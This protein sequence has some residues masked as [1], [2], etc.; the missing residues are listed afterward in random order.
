MLYIADQLPGK[1][2]NFQQKFSFRGKIYMPY[3]FVLCLGTNCPI[4]R[5]C[6]RFTVKILGRQDFF[7]TTPYDFTTNSCKHFMSNRPNEN[8]IRMKAYE[9]WQQAGYPDGKS[10]ENWLQAEK[11][12]ME[13]Y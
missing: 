3:D 6:Y 12:L 11:E 1:C 13:G 10:T 5:N 7:T 9:I 2:S 8:K 4:K